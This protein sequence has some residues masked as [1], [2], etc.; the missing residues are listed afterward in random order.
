MTWNILTTDPRREFSVAGYLVGQRIAMYCP[1]I[2]IIRRRGP[3]A[4]RVLV[5]QPMFPGYL[6]VM[7][8]DDTGKAIHAAAGCRGYLCGPEGPKS[9]SEAAIDAV[10][11]FEEELRMRSRCKQEVRRFFPGDMVRLT[12][13]PKYH[14]FRGLEA[15]V[16]RLDRNDKA[17]LCCI[18]HGRSWQIV[19][20]VRWL[21]PVPQSA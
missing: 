18:L 6:F 5:D 4:K 10:R 14:P 13:A 21:E 17:I 2:Q 20:P 3:S 8:G 19:S 1:T 15:L 11:L 7:A 16:Q 9:I 12:A